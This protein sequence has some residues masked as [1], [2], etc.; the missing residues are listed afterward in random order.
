MARRVPVSRQ[1]MKAIC[2][3]SLRTRQVPGLSLDKFHAVP[4]EIP[5]ISTSFP[6]SGK[7]R[8]L[9]CF[10]T[11]FFRLDYCCHV[12][13]IFPVSSGWNSIETCGNLPKFKEFP[14]CFEAVPEV[15]IIV[16]GTL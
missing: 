5:A 13:R 10:D 14:A 6:A 11:E 9:A 4:L 8:S 2:I 15:G 12:P 3:L 1:I 7:C 16:L